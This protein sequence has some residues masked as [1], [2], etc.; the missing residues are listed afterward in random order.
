[1]RLL[2]LQAQAHAAVRSPDDAAVL[3]IGLS[4]YFAPQRL[5]EL[6]G[7]LRDAA[8]DTRYELLWS[9]SAALE[10]LWAS[11]EVDL[12]VVTSAAPL[13]GA[14]L[15]RREPLAWVAAS[16]FAAPLSHPVPLVLLGPIARCTPSPSPRSRGWA[17]PTACNSP[18][19]AARRRW[20]RF[21][22]VGVWA[23]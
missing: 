2:E 23:V 21:A 22:P 3:S 18:A 16:A 13:A 8:P 1:M 7:P 9:A 15:L 14:Q 5:A 12:A 4:E 17:G 19:A 11:G 6:F 10:R 20:P